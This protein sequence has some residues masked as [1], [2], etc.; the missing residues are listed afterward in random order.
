MFRRSREPEPP[1]DPLAHVDPWRVPARFS[2]A[3]QAALDARR[4]YGDIVARTRPGPV[5]DR[6]AAL[7]ARVDEGVAAVWDA[8]TRA[9]DIESTLAGLDPARVTAQ[10]KEAKRG[11]TDPELA[12]ALAQ[13]F[14][15]VQRLLN[16]LDDTDERLRLFEARLDATVARAAEVSLSAAGDGLDA[17]SDELDGA[18]DDLTALHTALDDLG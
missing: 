4:R 16:S 18:V 8:A 7:G 1:P 10:Y 13:R 11:A 15:S 17:V 3:V 14:A 5:H 9:G 2:G 12:E 6:L